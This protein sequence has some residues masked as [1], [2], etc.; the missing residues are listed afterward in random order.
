MINI[1]EEHTRSASSPTTTPPLPRSNGEQP[2]DSKPAAPQASIDIPP[3]ELPQGHDPRIGLVNGSVSLPVAQQQQQQ[4][5][6]HHHHGYHDIVCAHLYHH[7]FSQGRYHDLVLRFECPPTDDRTL[8]LD[9]AA[10]AAANFKLHRIVASRSP[11]LSARLEACEQERY[12]LPLTMTVEL[13]DPNLTVEGITIALGH[14]Y[15]GYAQSQMMGHSSR[16]LRSLLSATQLLQLWDLQN[17]VCECIK[18]D[19]SRET[20][21]DYCRF[22]SQ[23]PDGTGYGLANQKIRDFVYRFLTK[24]IV[25]ELVDELNSPIWGNRGGEGY[26]GLV[27]MFSNL[28]FEWLK[29][30]VES[31]H[32]EVPSDME[33]YTFAKD[34]IGLRSQR[35]KGSASGHAAGEENVL[36][37][38]GS[39]KTR[40]SEVTIVR[41]AQSKSRLAESGRSSVGSHSNGAERKV[42]KAQAL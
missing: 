4:Q 31:E 2:K 10:L 5:H 39:G 9:R 8:A 7:G 26:K 40:G 35:R 15:A 38:F 29:K 37:S 12:S 13:S 25:R 32:F 19:M 34:V 3:N 1:Q 24:G 23:L 18:N 6:H 11:F 14:L 33:R 28:P 17:M 30:V 20:V 21:L 42:W 16:M 22:V 27:R 36:L 41:K